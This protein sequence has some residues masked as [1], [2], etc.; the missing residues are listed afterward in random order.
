MR[1]GSGHLVKPLYSLWSI[2]DK[3]VVM[4]DVGG[5]AGGA[6]HGGADLFCEVRVRVV[7]LVPNVIW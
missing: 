4:S 1:S 2:S 6:I 5:L 7:R 3:G